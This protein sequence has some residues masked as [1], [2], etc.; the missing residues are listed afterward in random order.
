MLLQRD[1]AGPATDAKKV[2]GNF[3]VMLRATLGLKQSVIYKQLGWTPD[4]YSRLEHGERPPRFEHLPDIYWAFRKAGVPFTLQMLHQFVNLASDRIALQQTYKDEHSEEEWAQLFRYLAT[5]DGLLTPSPKHA[6]RPSP[7]HLL[8]TAHLVKREAWR[9]QMLDLLNEDRRKKLLIVRG[10]P[11]VGKSSEL[12]WV[13]MHLSRRTSPPIQVILCDFRSI[14]PVDGPEAALRILLGTLLTELGCSLP[15]PELSF[16]ERTTLLLDRLEHLSYR[17]VVIL[18]H[19]ECLLQEQGH[20]A[21]CWERFFSRFLRSTHPTTLIL[22]TRQW[23]GWFSGAQVFVD[24]TTIP[25]LSQEESVHLLQQLGLSMVPVALLCTISERVGGIPQGLEWVAALVR[26]PLYAD[27]WEEAFAS[28]PFLSESTRT[29]D[30]TH[31]V[32]RLLAEPHIFT[33]SHADDIAPLLQRIVENQRLSSDARTLLEVLSIAAVPLGQPA[34]AVISQVAGTRPMKELRRASLLV[35]YEHRVHVNAMVAAAVIR[36]LSPGELVARE[37]VL[38]E[39]YTV[40][41]ECG[42]CYEREAGDI[43]TEL[44]VLLLKHR[45]LLEAA[46]L[47]IRYGWLS[48]NLGH[49]LRLARLVADVLDQKDWQK[50]E[51]NE[52]GGLL[53]HYYLSPFLGK[54]LDARQ[55]VEDYHHIH[56][57]VLSGTVVLWPLTEVYLTR[58]LMV[59]AMSDHHFEETQGM[60]DV[61]STRLAEALPSNVDLLASLLELHSLLLARQSDF[62]EEQGDMESAAEYR[63]QAIKHYHE[64]CRLLSTHEQTAPLTGIFLKKR[65]ARSLTN[66]GYQLDRVG[67]YEEALPILEQS[68]ALKEQGYVE[69]GSLAA[70]YGEK[71]QALAGLGRLEEALRFDQLALDDIGRLANAGD[72]LSQEEIWIYLVNRACLYLQL[73]RV[74][75]AEGLLKSALPNILPT[76]RSFYMLAKRT[77]AEIEQWRR[78]STSPIYQRDWRWVERLREAISFNAFWW[79]A[80]AGPFTLEE[81]QEWDQLV[82]QSVDE[83]IQKR[84][85]TI[86]SQS[87]LRE[88]AAALAEER[89]PRLWYPAIPIDKVR[90]RITSLL[91]LDADVHQG[92]PNETIR[93][94]YHDAIEERVC[95]LRLIEAAHE[96]DRQG[97]W[98]CNR[99]LHPEPTR[100][101]IEYALARVKKLIRQGLQREDTAEASQQLLRLLGEQLHL[102]FDPSEESGKDHDQPED[103][104]LSPTQGQR[105]V[106]ARVAERFLEAALREGGC[107]GWRVALD[108]NAHGPRIEAASRLLIL[109]DKPFS[110]DEVKSYLQHEVINHIADAVAGERSSLGL[111][112]IGA[113]GYMPVSEGLALYREIQTAEVSG[114]AFDDSKVWL[115]TLSTGL[116]SGTITPPQSFLSLFSFLK[117]F[118]VLYRLIR[119]PDEGEEIARQKAHDVAL[120]LCLRTFR[121]VP[122]LDKPGVC[123][124]KDVVYLRGLLMIKRAIAEDATI[125]E[126]LAVGRVAL[127]RLPDIERLGIVPPLQSLRKLAQDANLDAYILSFEGNAAEEQAEAEI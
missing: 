50:T 100:D 39:A 20:L 5:K 89:E 8:E 77:L 121:G 96:G 110:L 54:Q 109:P 65:L 70:S 15:Q 79:L 78:D 114:R 97:F 31:I 21:V 29:D 63:E 107:E 87:R 74:D 9:K 59:Y 123:Y 127:E 116:A 19:G 111:L 4:Q 64:C 122:D 102:P 101:E 6:A 35:A 45:R 27:E 37:E 48:F 53:L 43:V 17:L 57:V 72:S 81:Q 84:L 3:L 33:G 40:W 115:G 120:T 47:L 71:S 42:Q 93:D 105:F 60:F 25:P 113:R 92:E 24:E 67:R 94:L 69:P 112:A 86:I 82:A 75:E 61:C 51:E 118:L 46:Q 66:L 38:I 99:S 104:P 26:Q 1:T 10:A 13:A 85:E 76:R 98:Q 11:G 16:D 58:L 49:A 12:S 126:R 7:P 124:S 18:D 56:Q 55:R 68:I 73:G 44:A 119:R 117:A 80:H 108:T 23:P 103:A 125:L 83:G 28:D 95:F 36:H 32:E 106:S 52:C 14:E 34:L 90:S 62:A 2:F 22:A 88:L 41:L 91:E 30:L